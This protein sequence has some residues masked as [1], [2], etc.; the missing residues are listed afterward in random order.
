MHVW[1]VV[2]EQLTQRLLAKETNQTRPDAWT[3]VQVDWY[4]WQVGEKLDGAGELKPHHRVRTIF[5]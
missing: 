2:V 4:L 1:V 5:Y 3:D